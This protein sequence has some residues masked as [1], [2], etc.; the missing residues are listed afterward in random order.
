M[1][2]DDIIRMA[3][4]ADSGF[5]GGVDSDGTMSDSIIGMGAIMI[6]AH[7]VA[8][9]ERAACAGVADLSRHASY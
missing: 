4:E 5:E 2:K 1:T 3:R 6:F 8:A 9:A 7:L